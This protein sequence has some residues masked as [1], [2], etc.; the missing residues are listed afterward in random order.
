MFV[1]YLRD[2]GKNEESKFYVNVFLSLI[3][4]GVL[5]LSSIEGIMGGNQ[6]KK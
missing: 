5:S 2:G 1:E 6:T 4:K 3:I